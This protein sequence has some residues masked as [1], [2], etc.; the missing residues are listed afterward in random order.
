MLLSYPANMYAETPQ[1]IYDYTKAYCDAT[2]LGV[3]LFPVP[4]WGFDRVHQ[5]DIEVA[6][7]RRLIDDCP[8]IVAIKAEGGMPSIMHWVECHRLF[9]K[10]VVISNPLEKDM[11]ALAQLAPVQFSATSNTEYFGRPSRASSS[12]CRTAITTRRRGCIGRPIRRARP[13]P[14]PP[15]M[16][17]YRFPAPH[18]VEIPGLADRLQRRADAASDDAAERC[19]H[20]D[21]A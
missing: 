5:S 2:T 15:P 6:L 17:G 20:E 1:D 18:D 3:M 10:E 7:I 21:A 11:I 8:N 14:P 16:V 4:L 19:H 12:S 9:G 13:M